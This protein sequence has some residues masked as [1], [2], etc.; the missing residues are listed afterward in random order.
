MPSFIC[1]TFVVAAD[2]D[3]AAVYEEQLRSIARSMG[4]RQ[5]RVTTTKDGAPPAPAESPVAR[6]MVTAG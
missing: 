2:P 5:V 1:V 6:E 3:D 4:G